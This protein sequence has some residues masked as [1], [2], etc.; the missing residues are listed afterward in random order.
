MLASRVPS[1]NVERDDTSRCIRFPSPV[2]AT[3]DI[4]FRC[5]WRSQLNRLCAAPPGLFLHCEIARTARRIPSLFTSRS[6][7]NP[8]LKI[9][10]ERLTLR[11]WRPDD[12][13]ALAAMHADPDMTAWLA[14]GPMSVDEAGAT[15]ARFEAH[16]DANGF[17]YGRSSVARMAR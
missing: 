15:I 3:V 9:E 11:R 12:A 14:R 13:G 5:R 1:A 8:P 16:F 10:T 7:L 6:R 17:V 4:P 2:L